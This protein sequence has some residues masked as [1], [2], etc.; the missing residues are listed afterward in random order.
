VSRELIAYATKK[1]R[2]STYNAVNF[3]VLYGHL[4]T[5]KYLIEVANVPYF[6][7]ALNKAIKG[8]YYLICEYLLILD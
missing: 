6:S 1:G 7:S 3:P 2:I 5:V 8:G 4:N